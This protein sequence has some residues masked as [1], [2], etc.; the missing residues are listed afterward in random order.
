VD[1]DIVFLLEQWGHW[2]RSQ[3]AVRLGFHHQTTFRALLGSTVP[4]RICI[5]DELAEAVDYAI[6]QVSQEHEHLGRALVQYF[7]LG[8]SYRQLGKKWGCDHKT[9]GKLVHAGVAAV[10]EKLEG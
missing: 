2:C 7:L 9:A 10:A 3:P 8:R 1:K 5:S 4:N 6:A